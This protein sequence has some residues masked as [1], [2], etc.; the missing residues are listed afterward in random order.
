VYH[1][2]LPIPREIERIIAGFTDP[3]ALFSYITSNADAYQRALDPGF[4]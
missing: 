1:P 2:T 3:K 4:W